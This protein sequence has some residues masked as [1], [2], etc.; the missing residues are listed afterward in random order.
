MVYDGKVSRRDRK[1]HVGTDRLLQCIRLLRCLECFYQDYDILRLVNS[2]CWI[3]S[4]GVTGD[5]S[6]KGTWLRATCLGVVSGLLKATSAGYH[7]DQSRS[8]ADAPGRA[9]QSTFLVSS[10]RGT[11]TRS[12]RSGPRLEN[13]RRIVG[14]RRRVAAAVACPS[15][16]V[17]G[18]LLPLQFARY[19]AS[20]SARSGTKTSPLFT[21]A[22]F[23][24]LPAQGQGAGTPAL[25]RPSSLGRC[26]S[27]AEIAK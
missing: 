10:L 3:A 15:P 24:G 27:K 21:R 6:K 11:G 16:R 8:A 14:I 4:P 25:G 2:I 12:R 17:S 23:E 13:R 19:A 5:T 20:R 26:C 18:L 1:R 7:S 22:P 9:G